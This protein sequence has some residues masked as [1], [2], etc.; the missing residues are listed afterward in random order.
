MN[1]LPGAPDLL[2]IARET[3]LSKLRPLLPG[4]ARY[5]LAMVANAMA[6]AAREAE[7]GDGPAAAA[8]AR[9]DALYARPSRSLTGSALHQALADCDR[10]LAADIRTGVFDEH[11]ARH[12]ALLAHLHATV[13][14]RLGISN[15]KSLET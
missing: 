2:R 11:D 7:A 4:D 10:R 3:L 5:T 1:N 15:P 9:L 12:R 6:I 13:A 14:A 8:L